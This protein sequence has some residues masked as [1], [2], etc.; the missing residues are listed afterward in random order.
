MNCNRFEKMMTARLAGELSPADSARLDRHLEKCE[1]CRKTW[2]EFSRTWNLLQ[3]ASRENVRASC[4]T[5]DNARIL[6]IQAELIS[7]R[8]SPAAHTWPPFLFRIAA[9]FMIGILISFLTYHYHLETKKEWTGKIPL[10][11]HGTTVT[12]TTQTKNNIRPTQKGKSAIQSG[13]EQI[14]MSEVSRNKKNTSA[15]QM[16]K[17][18]RTQA[19]KAKP[20]PVS[21][22][23]KKRKGKTPA[24]I[25]A[26]QEKSAPDTA[27]SAPPPAPAPGKSKVIPETL[28]KRPKTGKKTDT[29]DS[30]AVPITKEHMLLSQRT[31]ALQYP[32]P[33]EVRL[34][35]ARDS[36]SAILNQNGIAPTVYTLNNTFVFKDKQQKQVIF[37]NSL[38]PDGIL[39]NEADEDSVRTE[40]N[41]NTT[42]K[43]PEV[44]S[45]KSSAAEKPENHAP[46]ARVLMVRSPFAPDR[47]LITLSSA[48]SPDA[49]SDSKQAKKTAPCNAIFL[50]APAFS[51]AASPA[52]LQALI[53]KH[54]KKGSRPLPF[55]LNGF[56]FLHVF[57]T[58][59]GAMRLACVLD[60]LSNPDSARTP[61]TLRRIL[62][63]LS[64]LLKEKEFKDDPAIRALHDT[65]KK[66]ETP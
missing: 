10:P 38:P 41:A 58:A 12:K 43:I 51:P 14:L 4:N 16:Q 40:I 52:Q 29:V 65:L 56:C 53:L 39:L 6:A 36:A 5:L 26:D 23:G 37:F 27:L 44:L 61:A 15:S 33:S 47:Y 64:G 8:T 20:V 7:T 3:E 28:R 17:N 2:K 42:N 55:P 54:F 49:K 45:V 48:F 50:T 24:A 59:P 31:L 18:Q 35:S 13:S 57:D 22:S 32:M 19:L 34:D 46:P 11:M 62:E 66:L 9:L 63:T 60:A 25:G 30:A 21:Q 1:T